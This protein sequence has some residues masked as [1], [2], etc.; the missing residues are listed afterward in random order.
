MDGNVTDDDGR[1]WCENCEG[2]DEDEDDK[3]GD[4]IRCDKR[5]D[6]R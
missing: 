1:G 5:G 3:R 6:K 2:D 4:E